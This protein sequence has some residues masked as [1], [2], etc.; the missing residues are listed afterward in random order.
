MSG[1]VILILC[2]A[3]ASVAAVRP[4]WG[5][6]EIGVTVEDG[7]LYVDAR[8]TDLFGLELDESLRSGLP[9][10][11]E[12]DLILFERRSALWDREVTRA[13]WTVSVIFDLLDERYSV[14]DAAGSLLLETADLVE[15]EEFAAGLELWPLCT[16]DE[17]AADRVH[18]LGVDFRVEPLSIEEVRDLERW[19]RGNV[20]QGRRLSD[21]PGQLVGIL[22]SRLG[23]GDS[24]ERGR[25]ADFRP[26]R[27]P[28]AD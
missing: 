22:R 26:S 7:T 24:H 18:Y 8:A 21:V 6:V 10:R 13:S 17:V 2:V 5:G 3:F 27:L 12:V 11:L 23:L 25:S 14:L 16:L 19:L 9:A 1:R 28:G 15:V 4:A 20:R